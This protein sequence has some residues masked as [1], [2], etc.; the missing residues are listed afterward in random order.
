MILT[1]PE[2]IADAV[3]ALAARTGASSETLLLN[4]LQAHFPPTPFELQSELDAWNQASDE[5]LWRFDEA[6]KAAKQN[7]HNSELNGSM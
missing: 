4:A 5:D 3:N 1:I 6:E 2:N 7:S